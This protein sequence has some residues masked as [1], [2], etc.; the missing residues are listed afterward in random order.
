MR[1]RTDLALPN[2]KSF[3]GKIK[4]S[5]VESTTMKLDFVFGTWLIPL[6]LK[7]MLDKRLFPKLRKS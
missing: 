4:I 5:T 1:V 3:A 7:E 2:I 6:I